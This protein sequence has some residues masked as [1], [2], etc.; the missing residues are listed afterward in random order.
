[1]KNTIVLSVLFI[2]GL[3]LGYSGL[4]QAKCM[5]HGFEK[6]DSNGDGTLSQQEFTDYKMKRFNKMDTNSDGTVTKAEVEAKAQ[7]KFVKIDTDKNG[8]VTQEEMKTYW[9]SKKK[10]K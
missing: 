8:Q 4:A 9:E 1:M 6:K 10:K 7:E 2:F 5:G 3:T